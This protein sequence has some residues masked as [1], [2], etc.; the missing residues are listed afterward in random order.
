MEYTYITL[1]VVIALAVWGTYALW[2]YLTAKRYGK[3][4]DGRH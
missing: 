1:V 2:I 4:G 3:K